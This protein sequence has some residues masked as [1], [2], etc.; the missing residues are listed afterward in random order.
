MKEKGKIRHS[1]TI[2]GEGG[3]EGKKGNRG[4]IEQGQ[5]GPECTRVGEKRKIFEPSIAKGKK[6]GRKEEIQPAVPGHGGRKS[7]KDLEEREGKKGKKRGE[8]CV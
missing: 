4:P 1:S 7:G 6:R 2:P 3:K 8:I 5:G